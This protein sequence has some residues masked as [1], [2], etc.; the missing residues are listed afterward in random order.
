MK[1]K[2]SYQHPM[3]SNAQKIKEKGVV[4]FENVRG[5]PDGE[6][7]FVSPDYVICIGNRGQIENLY[8]DF[9]DYSAKGTAAVIYPNHSLKM[10]SKSDDFRA[11]LVVVHAS[12][13]DD[14]LLRIIDQ[15]R[16]RYEPHPMVQL[17]TMEHNVVM[18]VVKVLGELS[19]LDFPDRQMLLT[20]QIVL[21]VRLLNHYRTRHLHDEP[22]GRRVSTQFHNDLLQHFREH[23]DI[24]FYAGKSCLSA[25]YFITVIK[26]E[27]GHT[28]AWW[29]RSQVVS[30]AKKL[31]DLRRDITVQAVAD[32]LGFDDQATFS[33]FFKRE[34]GLSP[35]EYR[36]SLK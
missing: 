23:R 7:P 28:A 30:E 18:R 11:T 20:Q 3:L 15:M 8:D 27:T 32:A 21:L 2:E 33:R 6:S 12:L 34:T 26:R 10:V 35:T 24:G 31:L 5:L 13:L 22:V 36:Q 19:D 14:P 16:Y 29:I 17:T 25:K 4:V 1:K 9:L